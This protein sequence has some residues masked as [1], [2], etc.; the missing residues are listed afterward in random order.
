MN[1]YQAQIIGSLVLIGLVFQV[2]Q[3][4]Y[5]HRIRR[6]LQRRLP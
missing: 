1:D 6:R 5:L 3:L 4:R 2:V